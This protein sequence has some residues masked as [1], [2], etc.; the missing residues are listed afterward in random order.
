MFATVEQN[1]STHD[2]QEKSWDCAFD[3]FDSSCSAIIEDDDSFMYDPRESFWDCTFDPDVKHWRT[4]AGCNPYAPKLE[5][6]EY[7]EP[8]QELPPPNLHEL[9]KPARL[10][11]IEKLSSNEASDRAVWKVSWNGADAAHPIAILKMYF[12]DADGYAREAAVFAMAVPSIMPVLY[13]RYS[14]SSSDIAEHSVPVS[15]EFAA[16][17]S[18]PALL[19]EFVQ[20]EWPTAWNITPEIATQGINAV[21]ELHRHG[22]LHDDLALRNMI[23]SDGGHESRFVLIDFDCAQLFDIRDSDRVLNSYQFVQEMVDIWAIFYRRL[24]PDRLKLDRGEQPRARSTV[25]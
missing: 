22:I 10:I 23:V 11:F 3:P 2:A 9:Q 20:G 19:L 18:I 12:D 8:I 5:N 17:S 15:P 25:E 14:F 1:F 7:L 6:A 4:I 21:A 24:L 13:G 16:D